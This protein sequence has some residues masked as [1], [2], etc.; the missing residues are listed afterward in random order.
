[1]HPH[2]TKRGTVIKAAEHGKMI[3]KM[4]YVPIW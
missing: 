2:M 4:H 3:M 1:M